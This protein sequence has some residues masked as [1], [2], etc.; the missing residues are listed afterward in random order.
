M[1]R[2]MAIGNRFSAQEMPGA[3]RTVSALARAFTDIVFPRGPEPA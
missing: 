1:Q 2:M 3:D